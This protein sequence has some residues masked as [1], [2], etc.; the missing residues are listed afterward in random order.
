MTTI[1]VIINYN[2]FMI[3]SND[4]LIIV[5]LIDGIRKVR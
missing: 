4:D 1:T 3:I 5:L 2:Y